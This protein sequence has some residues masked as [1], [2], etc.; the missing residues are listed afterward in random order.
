MDAFPTVDH[1]HNSVLLGQISKDVGDRMSGVLPKTHGTRPWGNDTV[2]PFSAGQEKDGEGLDLG[3]RSAL[4]STAEKHLIVITH[5]IHFH[6][7]FYAVVFTNCIRAISD[8]YLF[9]KKYGP[10][11]NRHIIL[12]ELLEK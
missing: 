5:R 10:E 6:E 3:E 7:S 12:K 4:A 11:D 9:N 8:K 2:S 1:T